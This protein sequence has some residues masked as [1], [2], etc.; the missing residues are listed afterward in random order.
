[1]DHWA[2]AALPGHLSPLG[3][4]WDWARASPALSAP[5]LEVVVLVVDAMGSTIQVYRTSA[6]RREDTA[7]KAQVSG[8]LWSRLWFVG[9]S[10]PKTVTPPKPH[11]DSDTADLL[12][13]TAQLLCDAG[14]TYAQLLTEPDLDKSRVDDLLDRIRTWTATMVAKSTPLHSLIPDHGIF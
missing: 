2:A 3:V 10:L 13:R 14:E 5:T 11:V 8:G 12:Q 7:E 1:M 4:A 9:R 6:R